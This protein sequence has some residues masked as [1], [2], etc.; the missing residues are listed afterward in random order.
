M[1]AGNDMLMLLCYGDE[2]NY[3]IV[4]GEVVMKNGA[5]ATT[6]GDLLGSGSG[7]DGEGG[8]TSVLDNISLAGLLEVTSDGFDDS[9]PVVRALV[10]GTEGKN[11]IYDEDAGEPVWLPLSYALNGAENTFTSPTGR[12]ISTTG[13]RANGRARTAEAYAPRRAP[14]GRFPRLRTP[15]MTTSYT[16]RRANSSAG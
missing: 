16:T 7:T 14:S 15:R 9:D 6:I 1:L 13:P 10:Y 5:R 2:S 4:D 8:I 3:E 11:Y 12:N